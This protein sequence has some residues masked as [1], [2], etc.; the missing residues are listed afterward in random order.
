MHQ[1]HLL[2]FRGVIFIQMMLEK[3]NLPK[4]PPPKWLVSCSWRT[5]REQPQGR[6]VNHVTPQGAERRQQQIR[7]NKVDKASEKKKRVRNKRS[8]SETLS[9][10]RLSQKTLLKQSKV[11]GNWCK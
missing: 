1:Y 8:D 10:S 2:P 4:L 6:L 3:L 9:D 11:V 5:G 7:Q